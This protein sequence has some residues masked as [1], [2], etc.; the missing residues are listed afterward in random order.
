MS[1]KESLRTIRKKLRWLDPFTYVDLYVLP[2]VNP[3]KNST[4]EFAVNLFFAAFFAIAIYSIAGF[5][6]STDVPGAIVFSYSMLP[7]LSRGDFI[8]LQGV[9]AE[10]LNTPAVDLNFSVKDKHLKDY[11]TTYCSFTESY[12]NPNEL[13]TCDSFLQLYIKQEIPIDSFTTRKIVFKNNQVLD[14]DTTGDITLYYS[15][16]SG[17]QIIHRSV[18]KL[19]AEDGIFIFTKGDSP[20]NPII[21]QDYPLSYENNA[22]TSFATPVS[23]IKGRIILR[24]PLIGYAKIIIFDDIPQLIFGCPEGQECYFP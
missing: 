4:I 19:N 1:L 3:N 24:I 9:N 20:S 23:E 6:L 5:L 21:D 13:A 8:A 18:A 12:G 7:V 11:A 2:K 17:K 15:G 22:I 10:Q 14:L 16:L